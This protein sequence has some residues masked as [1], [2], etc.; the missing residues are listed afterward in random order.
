MTEKE[1][2][3]ISKTLSFVL[4]HRP[5]RI[6]IELDS[7]GWVD[8]AGTDR[9]SSGPGEEAGHRRTPARHSEYGETTDGARVADRRGNRYK[10]DLR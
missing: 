4:R 1:L 8:V 10:P 2:T 5:D 6:G 3:K 7:N 9:H